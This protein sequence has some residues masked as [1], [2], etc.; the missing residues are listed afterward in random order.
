MK[1]AFKK[2]Y[3][4]VTSVA[5]SYDLNISSLSQKDLWIKRTARWPSCVECT[6]N[7]ITHSYSNIRV[8]RFLAGVTTSKDRAHRKGLYPTVDWKELMIVIQLLNYC[9]PLMVSLCVR[10]DWV[11]YIFTSV[12]SFRPLFCHD[13]DIKK[14]YHLLSLLHGRR[15][16][17]IY[18]SPLPKFYLK[19]L[20]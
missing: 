14:V 19:I 15:S 11:L 13:F 10:T 8:G 12:N 20:K 17:A 3:L 6:N 7:R 18:F 2:C 4:N 5:L 16:L 9:L 1:R